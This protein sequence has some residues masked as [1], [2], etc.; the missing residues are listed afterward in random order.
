M[1]SRTQSIMT[2]QIS[3]ADRNDLPRILTLYAGARSFMAQN[4]NPSQWGPSGYPQKPLLVEDIMKRRLYKVCEGESIIGAFVLIFG[5]DPTYRV[6]EEGSWPNAKP[7]G[8]LHRLCADAKACGVARAALDHCREQC[9]AAGADLRADTHADNLIMQ[10]ILTAYGFKR[11]GRI[12]VA[13]GSPRL[14][15]QL[16]IE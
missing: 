7:Y 2:K 11:C 8:T 1:Q 10:H 12:Y 14:A 6:I 4:G 5:E 9:R 15:Y 16:N 13:D 3:L